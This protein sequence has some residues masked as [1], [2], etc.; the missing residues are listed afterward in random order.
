MGAN[1][2]NKQSGADEMPIGHCTTK[3]CWPSSVCI[4]MSIG[5]RSFGLVKVVS[6]WCAEDSAGYAEAAKIKAN[7]LKEFPGAHINQLSVFCDSDKRYT[8][9]HVERGVG[10]TILIPGVPN[11]NSPYALEKKFL[12]AHVSYI[13]ARGSDNS[14]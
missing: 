14:T 9:P 7:A 5:Q 8:Q 10:F 4:D 2:G 11:T 1:P 3:T 6:M 12:T 13:E